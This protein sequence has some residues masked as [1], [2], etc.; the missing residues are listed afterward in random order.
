VGGESPLLSK[1]EIMYYKLSTVQKVSYTGTAANSSAI[2]DQTR[3]VRLYATTK[4]H[5]SINNPAVTATTS[6]TPLNADS[7]EI[8]K[9]APG[10]IISVVRAASS[11]DLFITELTE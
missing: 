7:E 9:V 2:G 6:M 5:V 3:L 11:G 8:F 4:C 10:N 1:G